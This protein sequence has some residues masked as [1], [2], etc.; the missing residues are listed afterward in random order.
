MRPEPWRR[1]LLFRP[2]RRP[3]HRRKA[4]DKSPVVRGPSFIS[5]RSGRTLPTFLAVSRRG[6][7]KK[8]IGGLTSSIDLAML[9]S[10]SGRPSV[11]RVGPAIS[12]RDFDRVAII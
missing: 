12:M 7:H 4:Q 9:D 11:A 2:P 5:G 3:K 1:Q 6:V 10:S 8:T